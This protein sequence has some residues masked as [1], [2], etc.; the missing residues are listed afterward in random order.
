MILVVYLWYMDIS[1]NISR[2]IYR[3]SMEVYMVYLWYIFG[4]SMMLGEVGE[5]EHSE[6]QDFRLWCFYLQHQ[7]VLQWIVFFGKIET[8]KPHMEVSWVI[9][10]LLNHPIYWDFSYKPT[11]L[12]YPHG[13]GNP[14]FLGEIDGVSFVF[15]QKPI[16]WTM[17][18]IC[19]W[20]IP[21]PSTISWGFYMILPYVW[22]RLMDKHME[23]WEDLLQWD[24][25]CTLEWET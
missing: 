14:H 13:Y 19:G 20:N 24:S 17:E 25:S 21:C 12:W 4:I 8:G 9:G 2:N 22:G 1:R 5:D 6:K 23:K 16:H 3:I 7:C 15:P 10:V 18:K 11:I